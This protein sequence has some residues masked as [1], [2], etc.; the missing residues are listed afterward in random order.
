MTRAVR[1]A[2]VALALLLSQLVAAAP[3]A[4]LDRDSIRMGETV[5]L[6]VETDARG[7]S[8]PDFSVLDASFRRLGTQSSTQLSWINGKQTARTTWG[9]AL[10]P[11]QEGV[12]GIPALQVGNEST[13]PL[14]LRVLPMPSGGSAAAGSDVFLEVDAVPSDPYV[15]QQ[16]RYTVR[17]YYAV[18]LLEGQLEDPQ[19]A[20]ARVSRLGQDVQYHKMVGERRYTV[21][22]RRF[23]IVPEA[24]GTLQLPGLQFRGRT[25]RTSGYGS[26]M[27]PS[28]ILSARGDALTLEVRPRPAQAPTP[29]M[30]A[31]AVSIVD[32]SGRVDGPLKVGEPVT[33][34][35]RVAALGL[36]AEQLPEL[37][38]PAI[39]GAEVYPD[40]ETSQTGYDGEW[41]RGERVRK[42]AIV[43]TRAG[44]LHVPEIGIDW[45]NIESD[46]A[47][48]AS[49]PPREFAVADAAGRIP[50]VSTTPAPASA[51]APASDAPPPSS[52][53]PSIPWWPLATATF[54]ALWLGTLLWR[55]RST[56]ARA[57]ASPTAP[58]A[59]QRR[60]E[61]EHALTRDEPAA[62]A[63]AII[64][65]VP[66][67]F[68]RAQHLG[69][70]G[71]ALGDGAQRAAIERLE[72]ALFAGAS[73]GA[74]LAA[75]RRAFAGGPKWREHAAGRDPAAD[76]L[77]PLYPP[78]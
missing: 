28:A 68:G 36:A 58:T 25:L 16:V 57:S 15:Q 73:D 42:F 35:I 27:T 4:W 20:G 48:R 26:L 9:V 56:A 33:L 54:A 11:L 41:M 30:P 21:V 24:S 3:R 10:E 7:G 37:S 45:W 55:R 40:Q 22:E 69:D 17:L 39:D 31:K 5:T 77:P 44:T 52:P 70:V 62:I 67:R 76:A 66:E 72:R 61:F 14:T 13:A 38:L 51:D 32:E 75:L 60:R 78:R 29:W 43:P 6:N 47:E 64:A 59:S 74:L 34:T 49:L 19:A 18:T 50:T 1:L 2:C 53:P 63:A 65:A 8:D 23:A 71:L 12:I 46:Q